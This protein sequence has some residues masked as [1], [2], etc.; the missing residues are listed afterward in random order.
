MLALPAV[1]L[2]I[3][4]ARLTRYSILTD[5]LPQLNVRSKQLTA[6]IYEIT[7]RRTFS[8]I[9]SRPTETL[10][11]GHDTSQGSVMSKPDPWPAGEHPVIRQED[12][13][14]GELRQGEYF[15]LTASAR[16]NLL[17]T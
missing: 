4:I 3:A 5:G 7:N 14:S 13:P 15:L 8:S 10:S 11:L 17:Q 9:L 2:A 16:Y 6:P 12:S 1:R